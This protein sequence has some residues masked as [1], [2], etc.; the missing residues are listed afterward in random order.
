WLPAG[1]CRRRAPPREEQDVDVAE[2]RAGGVERRGER[3]GV[4]EVEVHGGG[5]AAGG[6]DELCGLVDGAG[7]A[8]GGDDVRALGGERQRDGPP[9]AAAAADDERRLPVEPE[10]HEPTR[11]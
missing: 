3:R 6:R 4:G 5:G 1:R 7:A 9:E 8:P 11:R 10:V 2:A